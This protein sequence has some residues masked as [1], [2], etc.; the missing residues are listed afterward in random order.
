M[1][2]GKLQRKMFY[3]SHSFARIPQARG[4]CGFLN[5]VTNARKTSARPARAISRNE[6]LRAVPWAHR[7]RSRKLYA[8]PG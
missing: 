8:L 4:R 1:N 7:S 5:G 2:S 3:I 6:N